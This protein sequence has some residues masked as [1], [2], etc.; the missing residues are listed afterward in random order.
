MET[1]MGLF[2]FLNRKPAPPS[3]EDGP[4]PDYAFAHY[5]LR[6]IALGDPLQFLAVAAS[7]E[8]TRFIGAILKAVEEQCG[9]RTSFNESS[10]TIHPT[11]VGDF[12]CAVIELPEPKEMA[13]AF[14]VALVVRIETSS[15]QPPAPDEVDARYFTLEK[16]F[17]MSSESRTVLAEWSTE[18]H[19]NYG[20]GPAPTVQAFVD[21]LRHHVDPPAT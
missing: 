21:A 13:E 10:V 17:S 1:R 20:D 18:G 16:G 14:M 5:A 7:P 12:P 8:S 4:S 2:D 11:R 15:E 9:R 19:S 6:E 3:E